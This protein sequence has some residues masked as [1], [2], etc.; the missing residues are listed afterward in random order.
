MKSRSTLL[1]I[2]MPVIIVLAGLVAYQYGY[3]GV[4]KEM[5]SI[6]EMQASKTKILEKYISLIAEKPDL[7]KQLENLKEERKT[8]DSKIIDA[9]TL[10][11]AAAALQE[12]V[13]ALITGR[14]GSITS[15][16]VEKPDNLGNFR[17]INI[18]ID[19]IVPDT[20]AL[21]DVLY[22][23]ETRTPYLIIKEVD[24][25]VRNFRDPKELMVKI[26]VSALTGGQ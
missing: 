1:A 25:R 18:S 10:S 4:R 24:T 12:T 3:Q 26:R 19:A 23:V 7:E 14:G 15:E 20:R 11:I 22:G 8:D 17:V 6:N 9:Q 13:K 16:R 2:A 5:S 21:S